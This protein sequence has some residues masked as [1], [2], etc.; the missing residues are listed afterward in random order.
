MKPIAHLIF[1]PVAGQGNSEREL[2]TIENLLSPELELKI[3]QT[4]PEISAEDLASQSISQQAELLIVSGGD[5]TVSAVA[6]KLVN[7]GIPLGI[8]PRGTANAFANA[9]GIPTDITNACQTILAGR[10]QAI[11]LA[12]CNGHPMMLLVGIGLEANTIEAASR[13]AKDRFGILAYLMAG[14][15]QL[16]E[17]ELFEVTIET[18]STVITCEATAITIANAA[19]ATSILAQG[20]NEVV[21]DDGLLDLTI[22]APASKISALTASY[23]LL[24]SALQNRATDRDDIGYLRART[25]R[26]TTNTP[27]KVV[28]DGEI[29]EAESFGKSGLYP[30][31]V[32]SI[33]QGLTVF[34]PRNAPE[35]PEQHL[36]GLPNLKVKQLSDNTLWGKMID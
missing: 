33:P 27:Q 28:I 36:S 4:T 2:A 15:Q 20:S 26:I 34:V 35:V 18:E 6:G 1:N 9:L 7:T 10:T 24:Q 21:Y 19:P 22:F 8:V 17:M 13:E 32:S 31:E 14:I 5:G 12:T 30:V 16:Q 29:I 25:A 23:H 3:Y 11:D